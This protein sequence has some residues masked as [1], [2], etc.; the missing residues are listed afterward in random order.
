MKVKKK[1]NY[2]YIYI[3]RVGGVWVQL[4]LLKSDSSR[5]HSMVL[6]CWGVKRR[7]KTGNHGKIRSENKVVGFSSASLFLARKW[8]T[9]TQGG[10]I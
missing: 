6:Y 8:E 7:G 5:P 1:K 10:T 9:V 4:L 2:I 3:Y